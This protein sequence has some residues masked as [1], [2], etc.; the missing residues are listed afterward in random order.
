MQAAT[1]A[2]TP[3]HEQ[4]LAILDSM[5]V[6]ERVG[7]LFLITFE[8]DR[9]TL[10][11]P[12]AELILTYQV[13]NVVLLAENDNITGYGDPA[14][15]QSQVAELGND[16]QRLA[17]LEYTAA[18]ETDTADPNQD[19]IPPT[20]IPLP[21]SA[22]VPLLIAT[23]HG[24]DSLPA[25]NTMT[26]FTELPNYMSIGATWEPGFA[27]Q[28]GAIAGGELAAVGVNMLLGPALD[29]LEN[30]IPFSAGDLGTS[31][32]GGDP[33]WVGVMGQ[34]Y[35]EGV[36]SGSDNRIAVVATSFPGKG[37]SDRPV[38]DEVPTVRKSLEQLKQIEL[39]PFITVTNQPVS[40]PGTTDALLA[41]HI[42]YQGFQGNIRA[43]TAPVSFDPQALNALMALAE[44][45]GWRQS[46]GLIVSD[47]LGVRSVER[48]YDD[49]EQEFPHR[50]VAKD[51]LLAGNDL[52]YLANFALGEDNSDVEIIN[53]QD[54]VVW[55]R[56]KYNTDPTF[57]AR[58]DDAVTRILEM[59][60]RLYGG[61]FSVE[62]VLVDPQA[63]LAATQQ[64]PTTLTDMAQAAVTLLSPSAAELAE[65]LAS[66]PGLQ[67]NI[68][69]FT[70]VRETSQ[71]GE[72][73]A[74]PLLASTA[75]AERMIALYGPD[76]SGQVRPEQISSFTFGNLQAF[77]DA[78]PGP[79][80]PPTETITPTA[81]LEPTPTL[82]TEGLEEGT[83]EAQASALVAT[84]V[85]TDTVSAAFQVQESLLDADLLI[86]A[87]MNGNGRASTSSSTALGNILA[88]RPDLLRSKQVIVFAYDAPYYLDTTEISK[89]TAFLGVYSK[90]DAFIDASVRALFL[91]SPLS[92]A[93]PVNVPGVRYNLFEQTRPDPQQV[94]GLFFVFDEAVQS[95]S[96]QE[97]MAAEIGDTLHLQTSVIR[98]RNGNPVP[99]NTPV[100]FIQ[101]DRIQGTV[102]IIGDR[103]TTN[104]IAQLDYVLEAR[105]GPGQ[106]RITAE[107]GDARSSV[108][109]DI[110]IEDDAQLTIITPTPG[111]TTTAMPADTP[112]ATITPTNTPVPA[113]A[114]ATVPAAAATTDENRLEPDMDDLRMLLAVLVGLVA[115]AFLVLAL[116]RG[117]TRPLGQR[118]GWLLW[119][120]AGG[121]LL[122]NYF[123]LDLPGT[124]ML[125][126]LGSLAGLLT[127][128]VGGLGGLF[129]Y[130]WLPASGK[131]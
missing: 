93:S 76:G 57:M 87:M 124:A 131:R 110:A 86:F 68:V 4:A 12:I 81:T 19:V 34:A 85:P 107:S 72:C 47:A 70:D 99:D 92:G 49:T 45:S 88:Q 89:L 83:E 31:T 11:S 22:T 44:F 42:R 64:N 1:Q 61:D 62:N 73:A 36:H 48:L 106:F 56:E 37:S 113:T 23:S 38:Y 122:Y 79:I 51:A 120:F 65:R 35:I 104:G 90:T 33:Y 71:C 129:L 103:P 52:L 14:A 78:G 46:G 3:Y 111:P 118:I 128:F 95:P 41:T 5:S 77:L 121:L 96:S 54:T 21:R 20:P 40:S 123:A 114:T 7:Q 60:L 39:A 27:R 58:V 127:T 6:A 119:G 98:D 66:P 130:R 94:I 50:Q 117:Q 15:I 24:G 105:T 55:F 16:L 30:P 74:Q 18:D 8:G 75:L 67:D 109:V 126:D 80:P 82:A 59:K 102:T 91:E 28:V 43:T 115:V 112:T 13:G 29:V 26:G 63:L 97:P 108:E 53:I 2:P 17:L 9:A 101:N 32:F 69:I 100:R 25:D 116:N 84:A 125:T 10:D